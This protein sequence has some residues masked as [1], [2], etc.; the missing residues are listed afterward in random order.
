M[1][2]RLPSKS[3]APSTSTDS[4]TEE[5]GTDI[6]AMYEIG[7]VFLTVRELSQRWK[8]S[9]RHIRRLIAQTRIPTIRFGRAVRIPESAILNRKYENLS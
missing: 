4:K 6:P 3:K 2:I 5:D 9:E 7:E 1:A 8:L